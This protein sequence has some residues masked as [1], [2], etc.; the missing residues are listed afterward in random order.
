MAER[1]GFEPTV[2]LRLQCHNTTEIIQQ[3]TPDKRKLAE[4][5]LLQLAQQDGIMVKN[6][7]HS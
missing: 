1:V 5:I 4:A 6:D 3:L 2:T 7:G